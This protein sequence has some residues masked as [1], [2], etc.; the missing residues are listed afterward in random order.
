VAE[1]VNYR[2]K[3]GRRKEGDRIVVLEDTTGAG[4]AD[5]VTVFVQEKNLA[6]PLGVAVI[7]GK[8]IVSHSPDL[9]AY[10]DT[11]R[12]GVFDPAV[13]KREV[14][15]TGFNGRQHDHSLHSVTVGPDGKWNFN[16]GNTGAQFKDKAGRNFYMGSPYMLQNIAGKQSDDGNVWIGGFSVQMN[17]DGSDLRIMGHN[18]RNSYEQIVT[19][20]GDLFQSDNDDPP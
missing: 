6:S 19:S 1:G 11:N 8:I 12:D 15:L 2:G 3:A 20:V 4:K 13:D 18:Y 17:P 14:L 9:L 5:K 10:T 16:Q 7:D